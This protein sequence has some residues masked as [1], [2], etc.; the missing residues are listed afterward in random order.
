MVWMVF[1]E[2]MP[3][4]LEDCSHAKVATAATFSAAWLEGLRMALAGLETPGGS[5]VSPIPGDLAVLLPTLA[6]LFPAVLPA[7]AAGAWRAAC[8]AAVT[9][10]THMQAHRLCIRNPHVICMQLHL[11]E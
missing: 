1:A 3:E 8:H 2:L 7:T 6:L 9:S 5:L 4:A 11:L 10:F